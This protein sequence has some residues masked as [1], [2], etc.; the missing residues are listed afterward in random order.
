[1]ADHGITAAAAT[2]VRRRPSRSQDHA[3]QEEYVRMP[4][5]MKKSAPQAPLRLPR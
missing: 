5:K 4:L 3:K 1:M 2:D